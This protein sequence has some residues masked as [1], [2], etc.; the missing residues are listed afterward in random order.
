MGHSPLVRYSEPTLYAQ[1]RA[2]VTVQKITAE[3]N[4]DLYWYWSI[5]NW[6]LARVSSSPWRVYYL[7]L[8]TPR[9]PSSN[10]T[11]QML[12]TSSYKRF[13]SSSESSPTDGRSAVKLS[14]NCPH[15]SDDY[16]RSAGGNHSSGSRQTSSDRIRKISVDDLQSDQ[17]SI[18]SSR[19]LPTGDY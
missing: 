12:P 14:I 15:E 8:S 4:I 18:G 10:L 19:S 17:L 1:C 2:S 16:R 11:C 9:Y 7:V 6:S 13:N 5:I 3:I